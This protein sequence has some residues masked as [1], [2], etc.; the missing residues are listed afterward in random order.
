[1]VK[2]MLVFVESLVKLLSLDLGY[3]VLLVFGNPV[4]A[5]V[6]V[7]AY[8]L[9]TSG[10]TGAKGFVK[11]FALWFFVI[12]FVKV[13]IGKPALLGYPI[14]YIPAAMA[15]GILGKNTWIGKQGLWL[16]MMIFVGLSVV[17]NFVIG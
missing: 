17:L 4:I 9:S 6:L 12:D 15:V 16:S 8:V 14:F 11:W 1:M 3:F 13:F 10:K 2:K 7:S 5:F